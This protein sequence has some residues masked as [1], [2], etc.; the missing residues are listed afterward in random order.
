MLSAGAVIV[1]DLSFPSGGARLIGSRSS[2]ILFIFS[3]LSGLVSWSLFVLDRTS[4]Y[5][6]VYS[7]FTFGGT[8]SVLYPG[9]LFGLLARCLFFFTGRT[10]VDLPPK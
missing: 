10:I 1:F 4:S 8:L 6:A 5:L 7:L 3:F 2:S 9:S